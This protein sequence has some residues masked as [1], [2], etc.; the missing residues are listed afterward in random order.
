MIWLVMYGSG[1]KI[2]MRKNFI[3]IVGG[4]TLRALVVEK[5]ASYEVGPGTIPP[6]FAE[7]PIEV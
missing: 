2:G 6:S 1:V 3:V 5:H 4:L 7:F